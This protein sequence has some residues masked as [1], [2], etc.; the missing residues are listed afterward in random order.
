MAKVCVDCK[1]VLDPME[2]LN[3]EC[4]IDDSEDDVQ[5]AIVKEYGKKDDKMPL[6]CVE[7]YEDIRSE[8]N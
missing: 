5:T 1:K 2:A 7:C 6:L 3:M 8:C 4:V